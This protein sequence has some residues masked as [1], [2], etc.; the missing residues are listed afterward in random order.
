MLFI[1]G[2]KRKKTRRISLYDVKF[3]LLAD[4][5]SFLANQ[6]ARNAIAGAENLL[7]NVSQVCGF[8]QFLADIAIFR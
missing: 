5:R 7:M 4:S 3:G 8:L 1:W 6:K 2:K